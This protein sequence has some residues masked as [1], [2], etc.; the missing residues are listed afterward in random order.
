MLDNK[1]GKSL[2]I[3]RYGLDAQP[4]NTTTADVTWETCTLRTWLNNDFLNAA[5]TDEEQ[6]L[7]ATTTVD[8]SK[9]QADSAFKTNG[10]KNTQ[11]KIFLLSYAEAEQYFDS[12][13]A[14]MCVPTDYAIG[15]GS[16]SSDRYEVDGRAA[17]YWCLR[18]PGNTQDSSALVFP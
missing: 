4:Y 3:S 2:L 14:R 10:G 6:A 7:I 15:R 8:N 11:D 17:V 12:D 13:E 18:S 16:R 1:D 9:K 5:F